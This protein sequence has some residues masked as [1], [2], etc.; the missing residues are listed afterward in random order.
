MK[1]INEKGKLFGLINIVDLSIIV[2]ILL[3]GSV[4]MLK[5]LGKDVGPITSEENQQEITVTFR[6]SVRNDEQIKALKENDKLISLLKPT[7]AYIKSITFTKL[8]IPINTADGK[9]VYS[10]DPKRKELVVKFVMKTGAGNGIIKLDS[11]DV[12]VGKEFTLKTR[13]FESK[14]TV[15]AIELN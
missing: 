9:A 14:G 11:Q 12:A 6:S 1:I 3:I 7:D 2:L 13:T 5:V 10:V 4:L 15:E 8:E